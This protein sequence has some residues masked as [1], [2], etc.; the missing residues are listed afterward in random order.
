[1]VWHGAFETIPLADASFDLVV[2]ATAFHW[3]DP[4]SY[5]KLARVLRPHGSAAL[6]WN[7]HSAGAVDG[8][9]VDRVQPVYRE[10]APE[11][12]GTGK[13]LPTA[14]ELPDETAALA[15]TGL[16]EDFTVRRYPWV[17]RYDAASYV[18]LLETYSDHHA[19]PL[20]RR[21]RLYD[22]LA[23][24]INGEFGGE[25]AKQYLATLYVAYRR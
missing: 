15:A 16:F 12:Y 9:F 4:A 10:H 23:S 7:R 25:I 18:N 19:L 5:P 1:M 2:S 14:D 3:V 21:Q 20:E 13:G 11:L 24:I 8:G 17:A 6:F 22:G